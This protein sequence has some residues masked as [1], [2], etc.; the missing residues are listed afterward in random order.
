MAH[1]GFYIDRVRLPKSIRIFANF[2]FQHDLRRPSWLVSGLVKRVKSLTDLQK[3]PTFPETNLELRSVHWDTAADRRPTRTNCS[4]GCSFEASLQAWLSCRR[5]CRRRSV[6][7]D[8]QCSAE[9][10]Q[11]QTS[12]L[13]VCRCCW[14]LIHLTSNLHLEKKDGHERGRKRFSFVYHQSFWTWRTLRNRPRPERRR[15]RPAWRSSLSW[16]RRGH[17]KTGS[18]REPGI[19]DKHHDL[20]YC[21]RDISSRASI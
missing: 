20:P 5:A 15:I 9:I 16:W 4:A 13:E 18:K 6:S 1:R 8:R 7:R 21:S 2:C 11:V 3:S 19:R 12:R 10:C 17:G 14:G